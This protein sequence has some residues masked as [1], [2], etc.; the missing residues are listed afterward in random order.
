MTPDIHPHWNS[1]QNEK[2]TLPFVEADD[3]IME[4]AKKVQIN[5]KHSLVLPG[6]FVSLALLLVGSFVFMEG[7][8]FIKADLLDGKANVT[9][10]DDEEDEE[11]EGD[12]VL[13]PELPEPTPEPTPEP[14]SEPTPDPIPNPSQT[15]SV[16]EVNPPVTPTISLNQASVTPPSNIWPNILKVNRF[17]VGSAFVPAFSPIAQIPVNS[18]RDAQERVHGAARATRQPETGP[19]VW[20][21]GIMSLAVL[22]LILKRKY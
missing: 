2:E 16:V 17:T 1:T 19:A 13:I 20:V 8:S 18:V 22:P 11:D 7:V 12:E 9:V 5:R 15:P 21:A 14:I 4:R 6:I 10:V 3:R